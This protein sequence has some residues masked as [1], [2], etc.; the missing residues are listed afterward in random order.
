MHEHA[1]AGENNHY[2]LGTAEKRAAKST[3]FYTR[4]DYQPGIW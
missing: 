3:R 4:G 1:L 2:G